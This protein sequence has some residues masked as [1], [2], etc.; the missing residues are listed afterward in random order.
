MQ[1]S[2][3]RVTL[4][5]VLATSWKA[6]GLVRAAWLRLDV[7]KGHREK[8]AELTGIPAPNLS[9]MNT[10]RI[11]MTRETAQRI[12]DAVPGFSVLELGAPVEEADDAGETMLSRL[13]SLEAA[14]AEAVGLM[15]EALAL[16]REDRRQA[17]EA[18]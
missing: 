15:R 7:E 1:S 3:L 4:R 12:A 11:P 18:R 8:L 13:R 5:S 2:T 6:I 17:G 9:G 16:L 10:G 14:L